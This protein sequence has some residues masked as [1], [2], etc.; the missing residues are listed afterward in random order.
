M[1]LV[2]DFDATLNKFALRNVARVADV[3]RQCAEVWGGLR[4]EAS[5]NFIAYE[6]LGLMPRF[7]S[8]ACR[9]IRCEEAA[10][11]SRAPTGG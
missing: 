2:E 9:R 1:F 5:R 7:A 6:K 8:Y 4:C 11:C 10:V 3:P